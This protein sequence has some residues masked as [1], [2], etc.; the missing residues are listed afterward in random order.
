MTA[1]D[2]E[3]C[4]SG[5]IAIAAARTPKAAPGQPLARRTLQVVHLEDDAGVREGV[6]SSVGLEYDSLKLKHRT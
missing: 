4:S 3:G 1:E 6:V 2:M 5:A